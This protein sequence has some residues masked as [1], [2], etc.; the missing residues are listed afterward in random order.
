[1]SVVAKINTLF[2]VQAP[3]HAVVTVQEP[4]LHTPVADPN[5][6]FRP[7]VLKKLLMW[8]SPSAPVKNLFLIGDAGTGKTSLILEFAARMGSQLWSMS[9]SGRTR[10]SDLVGTLTIDKDGA[11]RFVDGP[12]TAAARAGGICLLNE[13]TRMDAGEQMRLVDVLDRRARLTIPE[14]GEVIEPHPSFRIAV[15]G[16][17]AG[18]GDDTGA[19]AGEKRGSFAFYDRFIKLILPPMSEGE[20]LQMLR[21]AAP[22]IT[23]AVAT[24]MVK[25]AQEVRKAFV[26]NG[27]GMQATLSPRGLVAWAQL[28]QEYAA[29]SGINALREGLMD[30][31]L[32]GAPQE[33]TAVV[34]ELMDQWLT[35][36]TT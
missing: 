9:C 25:L 18:F 12:L 10:F 21:R 35:G 34:L 23:E 20:E 19:Y 6:F 3:D 15:T 14:T 26:G 27:G 8:V 17:S 16:N 1:M 30:S 4:G 2:G 22:N 36:G 13:I 33:D 32:N 24:G 28:T 7:V 5:Y 31:C 29:F 11:T